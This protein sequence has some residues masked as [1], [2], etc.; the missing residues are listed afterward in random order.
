MVYGDKMSL[1][2]D[3]R[4]VDSKLPVWDKFSRESWKDQT[5]YTL[6][7]YCLL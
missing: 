3:D 7:R 1:G 4:G 2:T 5:Y 6:Q